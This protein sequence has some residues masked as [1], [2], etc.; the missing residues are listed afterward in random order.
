LGYAVFGITRNIKSTI[1]NY[2]LVQSTDYS[3]E[4]IVS[5][6]QEFLLSQQKEIEKMTEKEFK[7]A[8][9]TIRTKLM[10]DDINLKK[11]HDK[12]WAEISKHEYLFDRSQ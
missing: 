3:N 6:G 12:H 2:F 4:Y 11:E 7:V 10:E 1:C 5:R 9:N 8:V